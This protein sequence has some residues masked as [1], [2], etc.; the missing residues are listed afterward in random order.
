MAA[1]AANESATNS[2]RVKRKLQQNDAAGLPHGGNRRPFGYDRT[3]MLVVE[4]EAVVIRQLVARFLAGES[5]SSLATW[6]NESEIA[7]ASGQPWRTPTL[8]AIAT[9]GRVA[10]SKRLRGEGGETL[11][12][13]RDVTKRFVQPWVILARMSALVSSL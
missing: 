2:R 1:L 3:K 6:L 4:D 8:T 13:L 5:T 9:S 7:S 10:G 12:Q 11:H